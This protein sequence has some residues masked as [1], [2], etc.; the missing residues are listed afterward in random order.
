MSGMEG[1][2]RGKTQRYI[3]EGQDKSTNTTPTI[4]KQQQEHRKNNH[5]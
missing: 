1:Y 5:N 2:K 3:V 4:T